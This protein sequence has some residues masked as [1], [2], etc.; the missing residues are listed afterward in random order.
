M[1]EQG[2]DDGFHGFVGRVGLV[3]FTVQWMVW[4]G[5][6]SGLHAEVLSASQLLRLQWR[7]MG[8]G[9]VW[10]LGGEAV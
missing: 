8:T 10:G 9:C 6:W 1:V 2:E 3:V 5:W 4:R 7:G